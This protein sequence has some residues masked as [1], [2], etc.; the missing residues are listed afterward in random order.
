MSIAPIPSIPGF[1][2]A[3]AFGTPGVY[4]V[5]QMATD[6]ASSSAAQASQGTG[7]G[8]LLAEKIGQLEQLHQTSDTLAVKAVTGDLTDI[9]DYTIAANQ[10][11]VATQLTVAVRN[12]A[13]ESF[14]E[15]MRMQL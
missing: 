2:I 5:S 13:L 3:P 7:F 10:A 15:I 9:H 12:K 6:Q 14:T 1:T 11:A 4:G 8:N